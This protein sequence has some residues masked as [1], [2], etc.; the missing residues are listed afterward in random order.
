MAKAA[1]AAKKEPKPKSTKPKKD[2]NAP[3]RP[4]TS[5]IIFSNLKRNQIKQENPSAAFGEVGKLLGIAWKEV[6]DEDKLV[7]A[8]LAD[9]DKERFKKEN[10]A[11]LLTKGGKKEVEEEVEEEEDDE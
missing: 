5:F 6:S 9:K 3:K 8:K 2:P 1:A 4:S 10:E 7:Y 11:Y